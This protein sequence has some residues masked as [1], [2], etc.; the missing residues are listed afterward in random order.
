M[1]VSYDTQIDLVTQ[2]EYAAFQRAYDHFNTTLFAGTLPQLLVTLQRRGR[3]HGYFAAERFNG[4]HAAGVVHELALNPDG[5]TDRSDQEILSTLVHEQVH[6][7]QYTCGT[8]PR[9]GYHDRAWGAKMRKLGLYPSSTGAPG[10]K[11]TGQHVGH[12]IVP[13]GAYIQA[14]ME[15]QERGF[16]LHWQSLVDDARRRTKRASKTKY[17]CPGCGL[18]ARAKPAVNLIC[19]DCMATMVEDAETSPLPGADAA[20]A[21]PRSQK[22]SPDGRTGSIDDIACPSQG[23]APAPAALPP[24]WDV[25]GPDPRSWGGAACRQ[26]P[27]Q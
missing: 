22:E 24:L 8:P 20:N 2:E 16:A 19:G 14:Y 11:Q 15:L 27:M 7:W 12:Y 23:G 17:T 21:G 5:F 10:G 6:V 3:S 18:I 1:S 25:C 4:R 9:R 26:G 13:G